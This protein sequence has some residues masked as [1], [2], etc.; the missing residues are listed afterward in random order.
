MENYNGINYIN[1]DLNISED[2]TYQ[3]SLQYDKK[4]DDNI[5]FENTLKQSFNRLNQKYSDLFKEFNLNINNIDSNDQILKL[6]K[7]PLYINDQFGLHLNNPTKNNINKC[8]P[9]AILLYDL[10][11][12]SLNYVDKYDD[13]TRNLLIEQSF[14]YFNLSFPN[15]KV[16]QANKII[17]YLHNKNYFIYNNES[18]LHNKLLIQL[19]QNPEENKITEGNKKIEKNQKNQK[20]Q[21]N[22]EN[23][24]SN[25]FEFVESNYKYKCKYCND[26]ISK[27]FINKPITSIKHK[28]NKEKVLNKKK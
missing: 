15:N 5:N 20:N 24:D 11:I 10:Y 28:N 18:L 13:N 1:N 22:E 26:E 21:K 16:D 7:K 27:N 14:N 3:S 4:L 19:S 12:D 25:D 17:E 9:Y 8:L 6:I 23:L 2:N